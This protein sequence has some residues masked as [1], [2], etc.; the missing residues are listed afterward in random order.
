MNLIFICN[1][2]GAVLEICCSEMVLR[3]SWYNG[4][5]FNLQCCK[6]TKVY[7]NKVY[8]S[9]SNLNFPNSNDTD[10]ELSYQE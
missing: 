5:T 6:N 10:P 7:H 2:P 1:F 3:S 8:F 4:Y 9:R